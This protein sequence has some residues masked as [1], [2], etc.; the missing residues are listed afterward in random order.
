[1]KQAAL[2][3]VGFDDSFL[4]GKTHLILDGDTKFTDEFKAILAENGVKPVRIPPRSPNC[5][6]IA[7]RFV[8]TIKS[9]VLDRLILFGEAALKKAIS[10]ALAHYHT[11]R[12]HQGIDNELIETQEPRSCGDI[13]KRERLGGLLN[14]YDRAA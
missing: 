13:V 8:L 11:E 12:P 3:L 9:E 4:R 2:D 6:P 14:F 1:M 7:E 10:A 5:N